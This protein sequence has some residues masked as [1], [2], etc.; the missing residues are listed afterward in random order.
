[1][2]RVVGANR[3]SVTPVTLLTDFYRE[4]FLKHRACLARQREYYSER[5]ITNADRGIDQIL[6]KLD[7][8]CAKADADQVISRL[9]RTYDLVTGLSAW[10]DLK[11]LH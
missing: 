11:P 10:S 6:G 2:A 8:L 1:M 5:A 9:L 7:Q 3:G 4:E